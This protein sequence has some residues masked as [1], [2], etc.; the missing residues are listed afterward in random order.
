MAW[1]LVG[2]KPLSNQCCNIVNWTPRN[3]L[4]WNLNRVSNISIEDDI[5]KNVVCKMPA[6]LSQCV[7]PLCA[8]PQYKGPG[9]SHH[10]PADD[11]ACHQQQSDDY[12]V[13]EI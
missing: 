1:C 5:F 6:I 8:G 7:N 12:R 10:M 9:L 11:L 4:H 3:K 13:I 2:T